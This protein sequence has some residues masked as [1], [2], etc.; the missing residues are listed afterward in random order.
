MHPFIYR[1]KRASDKS[2]FIWK[3]YFQKFLEFQSAFPRV[4]RGR[5][6]KQER[7]VKFEPSGICWNFFHRNRACIFKMEMLQ[8]QLLLIRN[9]IRFLTKLYNT[10]NNTCQNDMYRFLLNLC[11]ENYI[12]RQFD[13]NKSTQRFSAHFSIITTICLFEKEL[14][15]D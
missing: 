6:L 2:N 1:S 10:L 3:E 7:K 12:I 15:L 9:K 5:N 14:S 11:N 13:I 4:F 8:T